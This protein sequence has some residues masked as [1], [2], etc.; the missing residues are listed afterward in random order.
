VAPFQTLMIGGGM[1]AHD[2]ILPSLY[3]LQRDGLIGEITVCAQTGRTTK[4]LADN[5][6]IH[7]GF[8]GHTF[9]P[10][11]DFNTVDDLTRKHPALYRELLRDMPPRQLVIMALPDQLHFDS[12]MAALEANQHVIAVKPLVLSYAHA[13]EVERVARERGLFVGVEYHKRFDDR[14]LMA[15]T[16]YREGRFGNFRLGQ[17]ALMEPWYYRESNFQNWCTCENSDLFT[18]IGCHY[19]DQ[20]HFIT[21]H[22]PTE[23]SVYGIVDTYPN[24]REGYLWTDGRV[25]WDN[26]ACLNVVNAIGYPNHGAGGNFQGLRMFCQGEDDGCILF[27]DDQY[28]GLKYC[29]AASGDGPNATRYSEPSPDYFRLVDRGGETL[30]PVGYGFRSV[31]G[32]TKAAAQV[33]TAGPDLAAKQA[34]LERI[35]SE[36]IIAT[37][38]NS[39]FNELVIEAARL[40]ITQNGRPVTIDY[41][42]TPHVTP[43]SW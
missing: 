34:V 23:V 12:I 8:P 26:G 6:T 15:R 18:Y 41:D 2:Q 35:D 9:I 5:R 1:I 16:Q 25:L 40:S 42:E 3:Q 38:A 13:L 14:A 10:R 29:Y 32:L 21:G 28:R 36:G 11:P 27:H 43:R 20:I 33:E 22:L 30:T 24:G 37:P 39:S 19:V 7:E 4:A 31:E 17:A